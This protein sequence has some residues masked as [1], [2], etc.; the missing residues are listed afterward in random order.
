[1]ILLKITTVIAE[2]RFVDFNV[3]SD[4]FRL[5]AYIHEIFFFIK[6]VIYECVCR[7]SLVSL[8][9]YKIVY[10]STGVSNVLVYFM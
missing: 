5:V 10:T 9:F 3:C 6:N 4:L 1:M 2:L 7:N 8:N